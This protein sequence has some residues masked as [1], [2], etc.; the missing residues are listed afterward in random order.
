[1][2]RHVLAGG[3][4]R[5]REREHT[6]HVVRAAHRLLG[7]GPDDGGRGESAGGHLRLQCGPTLT[8]LEQP[9]VTDLLFFAPAA[10]AATQQPTLRDILRTRD[11]PFGDVDGRFV[12]GRG[13]HPDPGTPANDRHMLAHH[14]SPRGAHRGAVALAPVVQVGL[15]GQAAV[16]AEQALAGAETPL[17]GRD[18]GQQRRR[19]AAVTG[20][21]FPAPG[22]AVAVDHEPD[23]QVLAIGAMGAGI[24]ALGL[25]MVLQPALDVGAGQVVQQQVVAEVEEVATLLGQVFL[26]GS[27]VRFNEAEAALPVVERPP[28]PGIVEEFG[29]GRAG[30]PLEDAAFAARI[31]QAVDGNAGGDRGPGHARADAAQEALQ[32]A[33]ESEVLPGTQGDGDIT[34]TTRMTPGD[35]V[36]DDR[37]GDDSAGGGRRHLADCCLEARQP[38]G[39]R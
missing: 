39:V 17:P 10:G 28:R 35:R 26:K 25:G 8:S 3:R 22:E 36:G 34:E 21:G 4:V 31:D 27:L 37:D 2:D 7:F 32:H 20:P 16:E 30:P 23:A 5:Q 19:I 15:G 14:R 33:V 12:R 1:M 38:G 13:L 9:G 29:Q 11:R 18:Q 24:T 6:A